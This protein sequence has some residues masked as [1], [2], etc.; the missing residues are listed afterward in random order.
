MIFVAYLLVC[1]G[2]TYAWSDTE[3][4]IPFRNFVAR[5]PYIRVPLLCQECSS[6]WISLGLTLFINPFEIYTYD[7]VSN[8]LSAI[9]GFF[10]N[11]LF[12]R[13]K[14]IPFKDEI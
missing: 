8:F 3:I 14:I 6:F 5:V 2:L 12:V 11:L 4:A 1:L 13:R 9:S 7:Y 10:I